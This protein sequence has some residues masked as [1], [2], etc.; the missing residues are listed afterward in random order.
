[1]NLPV[2]VPSFSLRPHDSLGTWESRD[3]RFRQDSHELLAQLEQICQEVLDTWPRENGPIISDRS[4]YPELWKLAKLRDR[5]SDMV[6]IYAAMAAEGFL[7]FY[8]VLRLGQQ[9]YDEHFERMSLIP[10]LRALLL[11]CDSVN[12][13][14][15]HPA[16]LSLD[17]IAQSRN[18]L[19]HPKTK[20]LDDGPGSKRRTSIKVPD[21]ARESVRHMELFFTEFERIVPQAGHL[22]AK[23]P[24]V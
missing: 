19:V 8:G 10:K 1:M 11:V 13:P 5:T 18:S 4:L 22:V 9:V 16:V 3:K 2:S 14:K 7:N 17:K 23:E 6:R 12:I 15:S 20:E 24:A 21:A